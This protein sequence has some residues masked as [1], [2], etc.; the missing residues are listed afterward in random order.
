MKYDAL[1]DYKIYL[2]ETGLRPQTVR[3]Y[4]NRMDNLL[5]G[6][7]PF[8]ILENLDIDKIL[9]NLAKIKYKN[10][11]SQS[12]NAFLYFLKLNQITLSDKQLSQIKQL[13]QATKKKYRR[14]KEREF[15]KIKN[16]INHLKNPKLKLS[17]QTL[18]ETGLRVSEIS[19]IR[20]KDTT[21]TED[22]IQFSFIG[23]GGDLEY[24]NILYQDNPKLFNQLK[25]HIK[26]TKPKDKLFYSSSYLQEK[27][28]DLCFSCHDLRRA[29]AKLAYKKTKSKTKVQE[30]LR[31]AKA[32]TTNI[33][34]KSKIKMK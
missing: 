30:K 10:H 1:N 23:K 33:Y 27:S 24:T 29:C 18:L 25:G 9:D 19:Q 13:E 14:L 15:H 2:G 3:T 20:S 26:N 34:L 4:Y 8:H 28:R 32:K 11:F 17:Y 16:S 22:E 21:I 31:H 7:N 5:N 12:K 6:Q